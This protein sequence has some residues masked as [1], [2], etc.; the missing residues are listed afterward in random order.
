MKY[1]VSIMTIL[2]FLAGTAVWAGCP[3]ACPAPCPTPC[4]KPCPEPC[5]T[6]CPPKCPCPV[7]VPAG[8]GSG[9]AG[10]LAGLE[11][12]QFDPAYAQKMYEQNS[13][14]IA[15]T[16]FGGQRATDKNLRNVSGE[17]N[18]YMTSAN[19]KLAGWFGSCAPMGADCPRAQAIIAQLSNECGECFDVAYAKTLST[20]LKQSN[21]AEELGNVKSVTEPMKQQAGF[22]AKKDA[23]WTFRLDRWVTDHGYV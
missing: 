16:E 12:P 2:F 17:I 9:P 5:P 19:G 6:P 10:V 23:N 13:V 11:C 22:L 21:C 18:R 15:V 20:L 3:G 14:I 7:A 4:P 1:S 8:V